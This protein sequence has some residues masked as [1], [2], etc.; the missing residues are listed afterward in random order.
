MTS[1]PARLTAWWH[2]GS[3]WPAVLLDAAL[4]AVAGAD[5]WFNRIPGNWWDDAVLA[6]GVLALAV[7]RRFPLAVFIATL[8]MPLLMGQ[9]AASLIA[10]FTVACSTRNRWLL[11]ACALVYAG[12]TI[13][14][15]WGGGDILAESAW[16]VWGVYSLAPAG[17]AVFLGQLLQT[18]Q[19]LSRRLEEI[20]E[21]REHEQALA[22]QKVLSQE[23]AHLARE[24]HD[25]VSHQVSLIAVRAGALQ[26]ST[27]DATVK[28]A[29]DTI[30]TLAARTLDELRYMVSVLRAGGGAGNGLAP[31]PTLDQL[32]ELV[33]NTGMGAELEQGPL[34]ELTPPVQR[35]IYRTVQEA[36][37]N[38]R[39]HA[40]GAAVRVQLTQDDGDVLAEVVN[41]APKRPVV[42]LPSAK[43]GLIGL[44]QRAEL[45]GG[46][47]E[48]GPTN[49]GGW[50]VALRVPLKSMS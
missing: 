47:F 22:T 42:P 32:G 10:L 13:A 16:P 40:P 21:V 37:T 2:S 48:A 46:A 43:H 39:K 45:L 36:L 50:R 35:A 19:E 26:V 24:M 15:W 41:T 33:G 3:R 17:A 9:S 31:Q 27:E 20:D 7:R 4:I 5:L 38:A 44:K 28:D 25:V 6:A 8:P 34:P 23:R 29:A 12:L 18:K 30:R 11:S 49:A 14:P 1:A